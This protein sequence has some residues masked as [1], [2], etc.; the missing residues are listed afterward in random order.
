MLI[1]KINTTTRMF[2]LHIIYTT[3]QVQVLLTLDI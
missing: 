1:T 3:S 2:T